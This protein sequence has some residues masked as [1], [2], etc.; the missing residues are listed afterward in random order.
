MS[1]VTNL[2][3]KHV[4]NNKAGRSDRNLWIYGYDASVGGSAV[5]RLKKIIW[6]LRRLTMVDEDALNTFEQPISTIR[7]LAEVKLDKVPL[8]FNHPGSKAL[9]LRLEEA[10]LTVGERTCETPIA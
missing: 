10:V 9:A 1:A 5:T 6:G 8:V 2:S 7:Q 3:N 4:G